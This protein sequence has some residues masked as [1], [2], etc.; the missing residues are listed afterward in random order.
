MLAPD[1]HDTLAMSSPLQ[2][3]A[4]YLPKA[5][6]GPQGQPCFLS[7]YC[8]PPPTLLSPSDPA[9]SHPLYLTCRGGEQSVLQ[10]HC[11]RTGLLQQ[12]PGW[13]GQ[14]HTHPGEA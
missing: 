10:G 3:S 1:Y 4:W 12:G 11:S 8:D 7:L 13:C 5:S 14:P 2:P 6:L 9:P